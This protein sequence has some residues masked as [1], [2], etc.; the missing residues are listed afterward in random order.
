[1]RLLESSAKEDIVVNEPQ[2]PTAASKEY[3][4]SKFHCSDKITKIPKI[5]API[6][7]TIKT[8]TGK[9]LK[10]NGD[11][12]ILYLRK[13][14]KTDPAA[15]KTNSRPFIFYLENLVLFSINIQMGNFGDVGIRT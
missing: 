1:M 15:K 14:P 9:V 2:N 7:L 4:P 3:L 13:A 10:I 5:K 6:T 8:L 12:V 11:S